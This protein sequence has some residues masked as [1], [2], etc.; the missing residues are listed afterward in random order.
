MTPKTTTT[1][2]KTPSAKEILSTIASIE[3]KELGNQGEAPVPS[4]EDLENP[5]YWDTDSIEAYPD[6]NTR[7]QKIHEIWETDR[8]TD[9]KPPLAPIIRAWQQDQTVKPITPE[10]D[11]KHPVAILKHA[12]GSIRDLNFVETGT[13]RLREFATPDRIEQAEKKQLR[14]PFAQDKPSVLPPI[15]PLEVAHPT[16]LKQK[17]KAG[18]V[19]HEIRIFFEVLMALEPNQ[20]QVNLMFR[21]GDLIGYLYPDGK[22]NRTNQLPYIINALEVLHFYATVPWIDDQGSLRRWRPVVVKSPLEIDST[23]ETPVFMSVDLPPDATQGYLIIKDIHRRLGKTS[24][25]KL[26]AYH[27]A[28]WL[29]DKHGTVGGKLIPPTKPIEHRDNQNNLLDRAE[30]QIVDS[31]GKTISNL[32]D[33]AAVRQLEREDNPD[34]IQRYPV[35]SDEDLILACMP[36]GYKGNRRVVLSR[37]KEYWTELEKAGVFTIRKERDGWRI[38]P[39][40]RHWQTH[41]AVKEAATKS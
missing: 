23:N 10:H 12:M 1:P 29:W 35:L 17:T 38:L 26:N 36:N 6:T 16:G 34:V 25:P 5:D 24:A 27:T 11:R 41:R 15:M 3:W 14:F 31:R 19:S 40:E 22:F 33:K 13:A 32:Y 4:P 18:A 20:R 28:A 7:I 9:P 21:L 2:T 39:S 37:A 30:R 8:E